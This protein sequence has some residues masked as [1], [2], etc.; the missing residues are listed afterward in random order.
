M[1]YY[2]PCPVDGGDKHNR[3]LDECESFNDCDDTDATIHPFATEIPN[4][5]IDQNCNGIMKC[6][7]MDDD[8][9]PWWTLGALIAPAAILF[10]R[11][12]RRA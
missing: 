9:A 2:G 6:G 4:D 1:T 11:R 10:L 3:W 5:G 7:A 8:V 12:R